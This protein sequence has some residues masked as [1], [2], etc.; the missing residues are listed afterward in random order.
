M[1]KLINFIKKVLSFV[2]NPRFLLCFLIGWMITNGWSYLLFGIGTYLNLKWMIIAS[3][4]YLGFLWAPFSP[5]KIITFII[6][7][8]LLKLLF[9]KDKKTLL[10]LENE[11]KKSKKHF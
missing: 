8:F 11:L 6:A 2:L 1:N 10:V 3:G 5:E 9:P 7:I 4:A